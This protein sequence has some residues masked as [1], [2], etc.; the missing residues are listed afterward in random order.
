MVKLRFFRVSCMVKTLKYRFFFLVLFLLF[1]SLIQNY[2]TYNWSRMLSKQKRIIRPYITCV[3]IK[4]WAII[5]FEKDCVQPYVRK[6]VSFCSKIIWT[7]FF[8]F[9]V[10]SNGFNKRKKELLLIPVQQTKSGS[11]C[12]TREDAKVSIIRF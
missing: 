1:P 9:N 4:L 10:S 12:Y 7:Q 5:T 6:L 2:R 11:R 8:K 3:L